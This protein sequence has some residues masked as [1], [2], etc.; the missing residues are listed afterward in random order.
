MNGDKLAALIAEYGLEALH[1]DF[2]EA[3]ADAIDADQ[4][5]CFYKMRCQHEQHDFDRAAWIADASGEDAAS[6]RAYPIGYQDG[7]AS[8][9]AEVVAWQEY[10]D[11][12]SELATV[13][14]S[15]KDRFE[16]DLAALRLQRDAEVEALES[17]ILRMQALGNERLAAINAAVAEAAEQ[18]A[19]LNCFSSCGH[20]M[21]AWYTD[22]KDNRA[23]CHHCDEDA[24]QAGEAAVERSK[25]D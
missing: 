10:A 3:C 17:D 16:L 18:R 14:Q 22:P 4:S 19:L 5:D 7:Q 8:R 15:R 25:G 21:T 6:A 12:M 1:G 11:E 20:P 13:L 24:V 2:I 9:D 23:G